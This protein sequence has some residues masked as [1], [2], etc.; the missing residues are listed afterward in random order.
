MR[1]DARR[2]FAFDT[3]DEIAQQTSLPKVG[4]RF[5]AAMGQLGFVSFGISGMPP[6]ENDADLAILIEKTPS[7]FRET[8]VAERFYRADHIIARARTAI[9]PFRFGDVPDDRTE[10]HARRL[11]LALASYRIGE[12]VIVP[13]GR[14]AHIPAC[15]WLA[16][17]D[18]DL[19]DEAIQLVQLIALF[20]SSKAYALSRSNNADPPPLTARERE[21]LTWAAHGKSAWE[22]GQILHIAKRTVDNHT[23]I[24]ARKLGAVNK[25]HAVALALVRHLIEF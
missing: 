13:S 12:G 20:T 19:D 22:I 4:A 10:P 7:G 15:V 6:P 2:N 23:Q 14:P 21:V 25:T 24:A 17:E 8:Y 5:A 9:E 1:S 16:G 18:L 3:I 11:M